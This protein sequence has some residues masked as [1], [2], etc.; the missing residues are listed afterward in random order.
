MWRTASAVPRLGR[1]RV[2][3]AAGRSP[4]IS[5]ACVLHSPGQGT[6]SLAQEP[7]F[8]MPLFLDARPE[9]LRVFFEEERGAHSSPCLYASTQWALHG[10]FPKSEE[11]G[12]LSCSHALHLWGHGGGDLVLLCCDKRCVS[13]WW[14]AENVP[15][16]MLKARGGS[17]VESPW[18]TRGPDP[19]YWPTLGARVGCHLLPPSLGTPLPSG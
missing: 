7:D 2:S 8:C 17:Q 4:T 11:K 15:G 5:G 16:R 9:T 18:R 14:A 10:G 6:W 1:A 13:V 12:P 19:W 3:G